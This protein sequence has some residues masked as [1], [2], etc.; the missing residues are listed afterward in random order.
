[1]TVLSQA[2]D[3]ATE[4]SGAATKG[5][6]SGTVALVC[7]LG[8]LTASPAES[9]QVVHRFRL[10]RAGPAVTSASADASSADPNPGDNRR[11]LTIPVLGEPPPQPPLPPDGDGVPNSNETVVVQELTGRVLVRLPGTATYVELGSLALEEVPNG[12][13]VDARD[14]RFALT[15]AAPGGT[16]V[17]TMFSSGIASVNQVAPAQP[18][19]PGI[20]E[21]RL[22]GGDFTKPCAAALAKAKPAKKKK[23]KRKTLALEQ[24]RPVKPVRRLWGNGTG[25]FRTRGRY[26]AATVRGTVWLT[27]DY[28]NGTLVRV[29]SGTV[30]V[31]DL[32]RNRTVL[33]SAGERYFAEAPAPKPAKAKPKAKKKPAKKR[34]R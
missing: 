18:E 23:A 19:L 28:C 17:S 31:R 3:G 16:T 4:A 27:E 33:V 25:Q 22:Q 30:A 11:V 32:V 14:G 2:P 7:T 26:S 20:T 6:C 15:V 5:G 29:E 21:L 34:T 12:T 9:A 13:I 8:T 24:T 10:S 1:V